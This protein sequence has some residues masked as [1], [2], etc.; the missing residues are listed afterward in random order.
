MLK[1]NG[2]TLV[3]AAILLATAPAIGMSA[4]SAASADTAQS[5]VRQMA[6][7]IASDLSR[8]GP[9][10][11]L[12]YF[13]EDRRFLM[14]VDGKLQLDGI[15]SARAFLAEFAKSIARI[16]LTWADIRVDSL[17]PGVATLAASYRETMTDTQGKVLRPN[18]YFTG[19]AV[20]TRSGWK[21]R[22]L[23]WSSPPGSD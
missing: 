15:E 17:S 23:H 19:V 2:W 13:D 3:G 7:N 14:A 18:G 22:S 5:A 16:E 21:L 4:A 10:A 9:K 6:A 12:R 11:W 1:I 20:L 8:E